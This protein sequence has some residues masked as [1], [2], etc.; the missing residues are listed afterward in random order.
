MV[1]PGGWRATALGYYLHIE[2][3]GRSM[4]AGGWYNPTLEQ[5]NRFRQAIDEDAQSLKEIIGR[6]EFVEAFGTVSGDRLKTAPKGYD[7]LHPDIELLQ[8]RQVIAIHS[9]FDQEILSPNLT[10]EVI[11]VCR[12]MKPFLRYLSELK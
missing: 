7:R 10:D 2:P 3:H 1:A 11:A 6:K 9:F 4:V 12:A 5:L 8:L